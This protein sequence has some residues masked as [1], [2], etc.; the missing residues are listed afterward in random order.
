[1]AKKNYY[2]SPQCEALWAVSMEIIA[3]SGVDAGDVVPS[4][5]NPFDNEENW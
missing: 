1:M 2:S 5:D 3:D 4:F